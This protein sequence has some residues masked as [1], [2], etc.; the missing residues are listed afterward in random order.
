MNL[1]Q[2]IIGILYVLA[3]GQAFLNNKPPFAILYLA[4]SIGCL[5]IAYIEAQ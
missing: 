5:T 3:A 1:F 4:W 2:L